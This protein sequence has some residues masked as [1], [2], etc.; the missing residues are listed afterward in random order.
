[1]GPYNENGAG[2]GARHWLQSRLET[3]TLA[4]AREAQMAQLD[5]VVV[6]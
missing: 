3:S 4:V 1:M 5:V 6:L 2:L